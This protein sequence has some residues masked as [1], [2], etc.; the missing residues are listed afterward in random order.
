MDRT[1]KGK[2]K[3]ALDVLSTQ[4]V[5]RAEVQRAR[6]GYRCNQG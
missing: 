5:G 2:W 3:D 1:R 4:L 6:G